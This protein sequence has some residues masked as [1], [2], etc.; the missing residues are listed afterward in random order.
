MKKFYAILE[1]KE[2]HKETYTTRNRVGKEV[3][4]TK[5]VSVG[6]SYNVPLEDATTR[7]E[8]VQ[9]ATRKA[10]NIGASV[11]FVGSYN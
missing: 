8:A 5:K 10:L 1:G 11:S 9:D 4:K 2:S 7:S 3:T 6:K